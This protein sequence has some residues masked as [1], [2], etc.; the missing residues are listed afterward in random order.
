MIDR[1]ELLTTASVIMGE[2]VFKEIQ[3]WYKETKESNVRY[4]V[5]VVRR[6]YMLALIMEHITGN[7][8]EDSEEREFMTDASFFL[9]C[10]EL[11]E[12]YR[13]YRCF[14]KILLCDDILIH[15]RNINHFLKSLEERLFEMLTEYEEGEIQAALVAAIKI[16]VYARSEDS[17]L[18]LGR[19]ELSLN[20]MCLTA[21]NLCAILS[22]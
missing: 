2:E 4:V 14:P 12:Y 5:Y 15:G 7:K 21:N 3:Q 19:Y 6:C 9:R 20:Y 11:S 22:V 13:K 1:K 16:H 18:L 17:L 10:N 8:M